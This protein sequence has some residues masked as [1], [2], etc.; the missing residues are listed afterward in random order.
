VLGE[1]SFDA[2]LASTT[3]T[4][5]YL[6]DISLLMEKGGFP[7]AASFLGARTEGLFALKALSRQR[8]EAS[9]ERPKRARREALSRL[10]RLFARLFPRF[11][12]YNYERHKN[13]SNGTAS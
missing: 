8:A 11:F 7:L 3:P 10:E 4:L 1:R 13:S 2:L 9:Q 5:Y 6:L 12:F